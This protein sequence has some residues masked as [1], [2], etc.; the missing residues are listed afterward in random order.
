MYKFSNSVN[1]M[2]TST[3]TLNRDDMIADPGAGTMADWSVPDLIF[4]VVRD[5][6]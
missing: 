3:D 2:G 6:F 5:W 1:N 4:A